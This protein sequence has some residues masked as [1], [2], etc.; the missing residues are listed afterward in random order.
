MTFLPAHPIVFTLSS[1]L[2][3]LP[4]PGLAQGGLDPSPAALP[5]AEVLPLTPGASFEQE[6]HAGESRAF[7]F[8]LSA[9]ALL[10][11]E[12]SQRGIRL[13]TALLDASGKTLIASEASEPL[14]TQLLGVI[15]DRGGAYRLSIVAHVL[16][17]SRGRFTLR[18]R[19]LRPAV[20]ADQARVRGAAAL[21][22]ARHLL[23]LDQAEQKRRAEALILDSLTAWRE[24]MDSR[25]EVESLLQMA[26]LWSDRAEMSEALAWYGKAV[27]LSR[28]SGFTEGEARSLYGMGFCNHQLA[29]YDAAAD[30]YRQSF[31][32]WGSTGGPYAQSYVLQSLGNTY[33]W[34]RRDFE[35]TLKT[36][37]EA[38]RLAEISG[39]LS[40]QARALTGVGATYYQQY[41]L[42]RAR[43]IWETALDLSRQ[44][45][46]EQTEARLE[47]NLAAVYQNQGQL[48]KALDLFTRAVAKTPSRESGMMRYNI[49]NLYLELGTPDKALENYRASQQAFK[50]TGEAEN[51]ANS[52][53]GTGWAL[54]RAGNPRAALLEYEKARLLLPEESWNLL[55]SIGVVQIDLGKPQTALPP[56]EKALEIAR[57]NRDRSREAATLLALG[58]AYAGVGQS[59]KA[60]ESLQGAI[61]VGS[62]IGYQS[63]VALSLLQRSL[64]GRDKG[65]LEGALADV[66]N[67]LT[68]IE[69]T[70]RNL[71][72]DQLRT[73]FFAAKKAYYALDIDLLLKLDRSQPGRGYSARALEASERA[74]ARGLLDLL[75]EGRI[76]IR[77]GLD[78]DL[79]QREEDLGDQISRVQRELRTGGA[80]PERLGDLRAERDALE[81]RRE[82]LEVEIQTKNKKYA[83]VR[84]PVPLNLDE[85]Q[86]QVLDDQ[87]ALL[88]YVLAE[89]S[90]TLF[91]ITREGIRTY[92]LPASQEITR[93]VLRLRGALE[94]ESFLKGKDYLETAF[95]LYHDLVAPASTA[96]TGKSSLLIVPDGALYYI[97]FEALLSAPAD[98]PNYRELPYLLR[99]FSIAYVPS[100]SVLA[101]LR[102]PR[103]ETAT[104][105]RKEVVAFAP[106][107]NS[108]KGPVT[109]SGAKGSSPDAA[110]GRWSFQALPASRREV[111]EI[112]G[113]Y[114]GA[115]LRFVGDEADE[116]TLTHDPAVAAAHRLHFAT[117]AQID[118]HHPEYSA[119]VLAEKAGEDGLLQV[120]EI[121][122]LR[123][124]AE[125]AVLSACETA[126]GK[127]ITGE[128]LVGLTR[129]FFYAGVPSLVVS[130]WNVVDG[131]TP[132]LMLDFYKNLDRLQNKARALQGSK[133][134]MIDRGTYS[135]PSY[136]APF[137][138]LGEP[139]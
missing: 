54:R 94:Q 35:T 61:S 73:G 22:E 126:L 123:L 58:S 20:A 112:A 26:D 120:R 46:D 11:L 110:E 62:E 127:E 98:Q 76:D 90:S 10:F 75:A 122:N 133:L 116:A 136:W 33:L 45:G 81:A 83:E 70:R 118:E 25:G 72:G 56:L 53:I 48:Q 103:Q 92:E 84:Y 19:E 135:H 80:K 77:Q 63:V 104:T 71:A 138:L 132:D 128:G 106:F 3:A 64:L 36:F 85:I 9:G 16:Q 59:D 51:E 129:A 21:A 7:D 99:R 68:V 113:L 131:P 30:L 31:A 52:L 78:P 91:V 86:R 107:A 13:S 37:E 1:F 130:L 47:Q 49:G 82:Q 42:T 12:I 139:R 39:D 2:V 4:S 87:T 97:P 24:A 102:E 74:R 115:A 125:M 32:V 5:A 43:E 27:D 121:F 17:S 41:G 15:A 38:R 18:A 109:R 44:A 137:I 96:L 105:Q 89:R 124:S 50:A 67:A 34:G 100:A 114:P 14:D 101:G 119:L 23:A 28:R 88:E 55:H 8:S 66:E 29:H 93:K 117:H 65:S 134:A 57:T 40:L 111:D 60:M 6:I 69:S 108:G 79:R 95:A